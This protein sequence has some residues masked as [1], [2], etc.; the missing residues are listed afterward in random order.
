M[1]LLGGINGKTEAII[2][3]D[4][5]PCKIGKKK[6]VELSEND[7][8]QI[9]WLVGVIADVINT[10]VKTGCDQ[11]MILMPDEPFAKSIGEQIAKELPKKH[12]KN[13][14]PIPIADFCYDSCKHDDLFKSTLY[15]ND[16]IGLT[17]VIIVLTYTKS[18]PKLPAEMASYKYNREV[19][20]FPKHVG[21]GSGI[22]L[23]LNRIETRKLIKMAPQNR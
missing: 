15:I 8:K 16:V 20:V 2:F 6:P 17:E 22:I 23:N 19:E 14:Q 9:T 21:L 10:D 13:Y 1:N 7:K 4:C 12:Q 3:V 18:F 5:G 11:A